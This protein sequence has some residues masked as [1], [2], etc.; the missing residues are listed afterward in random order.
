MAPST[1]EEGGQVQSLPPFFRELPRS[2]WGSLHTVDELYS[3]DPDPRTC[4]IIGSGP[5][6]KG[7][8]FEQLNRPYFFTMAINDEAFKNRDKYRPDVWIFND[9]NVCERYTGYDVDENITIVSKTANVN[10]AIVDSYKRKAI[11]SWLHR[12]HEY[13]T[14]RRWFG[15]SPHLYMHRTTAAPA[16]CL[17]TRMGFKRI[18]LLGI[19]FYTAG[20]SY[21][22]ANGLN[23]KVSARMLPRRSKVELQVN[24]RGEVESYM[25]DRHLRM[26]MDLTHVCEV[27]RK[28]RWDGTIYQTS[29]QSPLSCFPKATWGEVGRNPAEVR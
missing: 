16:I 18:V 2:G 7:F 13:T 20:K 21:Y 5:S 28:E 24:E 14:T 25:E 3:D 17:A 12:I 9:W 22:Y 11:P 6:L 27:L 8:P 10:Q 23:P 26:I 29:M 1:L 19:D 4:C 15:A